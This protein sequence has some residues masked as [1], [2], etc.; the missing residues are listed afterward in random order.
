[1]LIYALPS[2]LKDDTLSFSNF[3]INYYTLGLAKKSIYL[4]ENLTPEQRKAIMDRIEADRH[5]Q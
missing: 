4:M 1:L 3:L 5:R 2:V